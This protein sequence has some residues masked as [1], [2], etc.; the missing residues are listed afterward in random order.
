M[1][2][3]SIHYPSQIQLVKRG[4]NILNLLINF[5]T[6]RE[7]LD[8]KMCSVKTTTI[9]NVKGLKSRTFHGLYNNVLLI[10]RPN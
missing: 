6:I 2:H 8:Y 4:K 3:R 9:R 1:K 10:V 7:N 5:P